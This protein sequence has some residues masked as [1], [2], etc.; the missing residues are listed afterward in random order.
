[1]RDFWNTLFDEGE[2]T[3]FSVNAYGISVAKVDSVLFKNHFNFFSINPLH[4]RRLDANVTAYRNILLEFDEHSLAEQ[5]KII[6]D[7]PYSTLVYSGGKSTHAIISLDKPLETR[8]EYDN[9]VKAIMAKC[10]EA[11][12]STK[13]P[14]RFS[15]TPGAMR[16]GVEQ[17][18]LDVRNRVSLEALQAWL[19]PIDLKTELPEYE[20]TQF[21]GIMKPTTRFFLHFG[22]EDG[23]WNVSLFK[24]ACDLF[25]CGKTI[26]QV[27]SMIYN[28]NHLLDKED[29]S[30]IKSAYKKVKGVE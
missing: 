12:P 16:G 15:R 7:I 19:G 17:S 13:N 1:M 28:I 14:S 27:E 11:D 10:K 25:R 18:L 3:C 2:G 30:T 8:A 23:N 20:H 29:K 4:T 6:K 9:L 24:A 26:E 22:A 21:H 5:A